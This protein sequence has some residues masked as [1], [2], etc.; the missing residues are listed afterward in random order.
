MKKILSLLVGILTMFSISSC[1]SD[2]AVDNTLSSNYVSPVSKVTTKEAGTPM[3]VS[4]FIDLVKS[5]CT[6]MELDFLHSLNPNDTLYVHKQSN[7]N[8]PKLNKENIDVYK[9]LVSK[10]ISL[11]PLE[12]E[13]VI[14]K[15]VQSRAW[16]DIIEYRIA[17][18]G[19]KSG[20]NSIL[21]GEVRLLADVSYTYNVTQSIIEKSWGCSI[22]VYANAQG[23]PSIF[24][25]FKDQGSSAHPADNIT[26]TYSVMGQVVLGAAFGDFGAGAPIEQ[27]SEFGSFIVGY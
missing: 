17:T 24:L 27:V 7:V 8:Y 15:K 9:E 5:K 4:D 3:K 26:I 14:Q 16:D 12:I 6:D 20:Y 19:V 13:P 2:D 23:N 11:S 1:S 22:A 21:E 10:K 25:D 18:V